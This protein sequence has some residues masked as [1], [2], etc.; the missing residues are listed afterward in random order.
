MPNNKKVV[1]GGRHFVPPPPPPPGCDEPKKLGLDRVKFLAEKFMD[2]KL[3]WPILKPGS[4][5]MTVV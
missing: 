3:N 5:K 2:R 4:N 1:M